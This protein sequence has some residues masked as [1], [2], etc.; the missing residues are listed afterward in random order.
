MRWHSE[1]KKGNKMTVATDT[2]SRVSRF[3]DKRLTELL[4]VKT[5]KEIAQEAGFPNPNIITMFKTGQSKVPLDRVPG[6]AKALD[7]DVVYLFRLAAEQY[8]KPEVIRVL[9]QVFGAA[10]SKNEMEIIAKIRELSGDQDPQLSAKLTKKLT[11]AF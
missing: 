10:V 3:I 2:K 8:F 4:S 11:E 5:Q 9:D 7:V 6:L 1:K